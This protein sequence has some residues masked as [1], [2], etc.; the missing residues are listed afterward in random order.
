[1]W[2]LAGGQGGAGQGRMGKWAG[3]KDWRRGEKNRRTRHTQYIHTYIYVLP[4]MDTKKSVLYTWQNKK[5]NSWVANICATTA[6][7]IFLFYFSHLLMWWRAA[8]L[9]TVMRRRDKLTLPFPLPPTH[10][11]K[12]PKT[13]QLMSHRGC[14]WIGLDWFRIQNLAEASI[15]QQQ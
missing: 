9:L 15:Q 12:Q 11:E 14:E 5:E 8:A 13:K 1:M 3:K 2:A 10:T 7:R 4:C 6:L